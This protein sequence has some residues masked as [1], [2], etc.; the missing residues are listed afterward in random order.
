MSSPTSCTPAVQ[1]SKARGPHAFFVPNTEDAFRELAST[2]ITFASCTL[3]GLLQ[4]Y[5]RRAED[6]YRS[7]ERGKDE[8]CAGLRNEVLRPLLIAA[9]QIATNAQ[10][11]RAM[12]RDAI[13]EAAEDPEGAADLLSGAE[14]EASAAARKADTLAVEIGKL[15]QNIAG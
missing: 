14:T 6:Q 5:L 2:G 3:P 12:V 4:G 7:P 9:L 8:I 11:A 13:K 1:G 10:A 15:A